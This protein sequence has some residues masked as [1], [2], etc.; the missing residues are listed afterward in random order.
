M[1]TEKEGKRQKGER[2]GGEEG[3][4]KIIVSYLV[5]NGWEKI[6][7]VESLIGK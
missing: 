4:R 7:K 3:D 2:K 6:S 5:G 1:K